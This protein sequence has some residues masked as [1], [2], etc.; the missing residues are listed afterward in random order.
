MIEIINLVLLAIVCMLLIAM[1]LRKK[2]EG[3]VLLE[4][5]V[6]E[7]EKF[8]MRIE[9]A[10]REDFRNNREELGTALE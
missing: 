5:K 7:L 3:S 6:D 1:F 4:R 8:L 10:L 2:D 9:N